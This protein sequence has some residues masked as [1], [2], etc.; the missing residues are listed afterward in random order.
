MRAL[1]KQ[2]TSET[3]RRLDDAFGGLDLTTLRGYTLFLSAHQRAYAALEASDMADASLRST[4]HIV[5]DLLRRDL[6]TLGVPV[7][8]VESANTGASGHPLGVHYV[9]AGSHF[10]KRVL[11]KRWSRSKDERVLSS[12]HYLKGETLREDWSSILAA[13]A[14][15][16]PDDATADAVIH[17]ALLTFNLFGKSLK[18]AAD[19]EME[20]RFEPA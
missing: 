7:A 4:L 1:L 3:H 20:P 5:H 2:R 13:L 12:A 11:L 16:P 10:G 14:E 6:S 15:I 19:T 9:L 18:E 8:T 17:G